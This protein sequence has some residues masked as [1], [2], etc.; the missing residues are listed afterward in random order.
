MDWGAGKNQNIREFL[1]EGD[2][3]R[4]EYSFDGP[5]LGG[6]GFTETYTVGNGIQEITR[7]GGAKILV[8]PSWESDKVLRVQ[9]MNPAKQT[10]GWAKTLLSGGQDEDSQQQMVAG[11]KEDAPLGD[12]IDVHR[13][14]LEDDSLVL[15]ADSSQSGGPV[16]KWFLKRLI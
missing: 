6:L 14:Y 4:M 8:D 15:E 7:M 11:E 5:G 3:I 13:F 16:V 12:V 10:K 1:Q 2:S 9:N